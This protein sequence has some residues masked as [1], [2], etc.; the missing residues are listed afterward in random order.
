MERTIADVE[1]ETG[2]DDYAKLPECVQQYYSREEFLWLSEEQKAGLI[3]AECE[4][5]W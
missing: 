4:P 1:R 2:N 5:E 3:Q